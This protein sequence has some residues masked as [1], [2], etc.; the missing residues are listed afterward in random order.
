MSVGTGGHGHE[1]S[2]PCKTL[3]QS[4]KHCTGSRF[5]ERIVRM[6]LELYMIHNLRQMSERRSNILVVGA[7]PNSTATIPP[8][9]SPTSVSRVSIVSMVTCLDFTGGLSISM[10]SLQ[11]QQHVFKFTAHSC[12]IFILMHI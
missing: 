7:I 2:Y 3:I 4:F 9:L 10:L 8:A 12:C 6:L 11:R 1:I 5:K